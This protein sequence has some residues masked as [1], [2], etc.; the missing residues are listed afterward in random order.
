VSPRFHPSDERLL[1][2]VTGAI[3]LGPSLVVGAHL[4]ACPACQAKVAVDEA[5][6]GALFECLPPAQL[7]PDALALTLARAERPR[8]EPPPSPP[9][10]ADWVG[11]SPVLSAAYRRRRWAAPGV[12]VAPISRGPGAAR[13]YL[14]RVG[15]GMSVPRHTH[16]GL[17]AVC[18]LKGAFD[19]RG[20]VHGPGDF[21]ESDGSVEHKPMI[22]RDGECVCLVAADGALVPRDWVGR[23]FQPLVRI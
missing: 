17:E 14:L 13:A 3:P 15:A 6:G 22:T 20:D 5:V 21:A 7:D 8:A 18:V 9:A 12:W 1:D 10:P 2:Y 4:R 19:D 23:L 11:A 16:H